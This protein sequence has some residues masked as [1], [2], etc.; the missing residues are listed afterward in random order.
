MCDNWHKMKNFVAD[1]GFAPE[2][3]SLDRIDN[4]GNYGPENCR[5]ADSKT[6]SRNRRNVVMNEF[7]AE[8]VRR[9][10]AMNI[11]AKAVSDLLCVS[12]YAIEDIYKG[13]TW[14]D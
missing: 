1:M 6:Q 3:M 9:L 8:T 10:K 7:S 14:R 4:N 12:V 13:A 11:P 2:G 5:W